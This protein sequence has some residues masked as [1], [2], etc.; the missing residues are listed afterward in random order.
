M[1][2]IAKMLV[3][4]TT[5]LTERTA[6]MFSQV[7]REFESCV[8]WMPDA[9]I[10]YL[11]PVSGI[12]VYPKSE[13]GF[14][15]PLSDDMFEDHTIRSYMSGELPAIIDYARVLGCDW[16]MFDRD[17]PVEPALQSYDW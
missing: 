1:V 3:L 5:H 16:L 14:F 11:R 8:P 10:E 15:V 2:E 9:D 6:D 7:V 13:Y 4:S 17:G 12:V